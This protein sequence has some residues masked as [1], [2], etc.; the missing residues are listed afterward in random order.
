MNSARHPRIGYRPGE[1]HS[2]AMRRYRRRIAE[3]RD[4]VCMY[5]CTVTPGKRRFMRAFYGVEMKWLAL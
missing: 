3:H 2:D 4:Y 5:D 1:T